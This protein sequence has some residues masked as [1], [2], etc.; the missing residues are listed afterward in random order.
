MRHL[1]SI[2]FCICCLW[3]ILVLVLQKLLPLSHSTGWMY[4]AIAMSVLDRLA[5]SLS[6]LGKR[7][8]ARV[9]VAVTFP[10]PSVSSGVEARGPSP[11]FN[12]TFCVSD[13][14]SQK[15]WVSGSLLD[16]IY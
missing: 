9:C 15:S 5:E 2:S 12:K 10:Y 6:D 3:L 16:W 13:G 4:R 1:A 11:Y 7:P 8:H 14:A